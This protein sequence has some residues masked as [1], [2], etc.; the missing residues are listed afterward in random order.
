M[1]RKEGWRI[2]GIDWIVTGAG[3]VQLGPGDNRGVVV[4]GGLSEKFSVGDLDPAA[5]PDD[6]QGTLVD[7]V[8]DRAERLGQKERGLLTGVEEAGKVGVGG[9]FH[10]HKRK[11]RRTPLRPVVLP[12][13][14]VFTCGG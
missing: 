10:V 7:L 9:C 8:I 6:A 14:S 2:A 13:H 5:L 11:Y 3:P 1:S 4:D 12:S